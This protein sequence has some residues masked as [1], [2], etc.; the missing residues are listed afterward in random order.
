MATGGA[1]PNAAGTIGTLQPPNA[2][3]TASVG[4]DKRQSRRSL[5]GCSND[6]APVTH[7]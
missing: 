6:A 3:M 2:G 1:A 5:R 7:E 4:A